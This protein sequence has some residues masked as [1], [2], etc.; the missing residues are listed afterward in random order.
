MKIKNKRGDI[1]VVIL[2]VGVVAICALAIF[3][4]IDSSNKISKNFVGPGLIE[5]VLELKEEMR[6]YGEDS[7]GKIAGP[8]N[9]NFFGART[10]DSGWAEIIVDGESIVG[11]FFE[12]P[13]KKKRLVSVTYEIK[14]DTQT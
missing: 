3:S 8:L 6:L 9:I 14:K 4:F 5:D 13:D 7:Y 10:G 12:K 11:E 1:P 2:V